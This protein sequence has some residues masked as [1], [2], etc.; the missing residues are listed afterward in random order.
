MRSSDPRSTRPSCR[1]V[2]LSAGVGAGLL[3][4]AA[5]IQAAGGGAVAAG[6][7][8]T[9][10]ARTMS[11]AAWTITTAARTTT[12]A[13]AARTTTTAARTTTTAARATSAAAPAS[14]QEPPGWRWLGPDGEPLPFS[15]DDDVL[16]FLRHAEVLE[17]ELIEGSQNDPLR[18]LLER[19]GVR[20]RAIF[21]TVDR[22]W[23]REWIRGRF[24]VSLRDS[25][26]SEVAAYRLARLLGIDRIPPAVLR[27]I[28]GE[29]GS[30]QLWIEDVETHAEIIRRQETPENPE[31]WARQ[32][33]TVWIFD[34]L[35]YNEDRHPGNLLVDRNGRMW[36]VD[37]TQ[38]FQYDEHLLHREN[39]A[40]IGAGLWERIRASTE[41]EARAAVDN[42]LD[43]EQL[44][45]LLERR[46]LLI[47]HIQGLIDER[48]ADAVL[49]HDGPGI[50]PRDEVEAAGAP[51]PSSSRVRRKLGTNVST[52]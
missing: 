4:A 48:G 51:Q 50:L 12:T 37:H 16:E 29:P 6:T 8:P 10:A 25:Y 27:E 44:E 49:R 31:R 2:G 42:V 15:S 18:V 9:D 45:A 34:N 19:D 33:N 20:A 13:A 39:V 17:S 35:V 24:H 3:L 47:E 26:R 30:L 32:L 11:D 36:M 43:D 38:A 23:H 5:G 46:R 1:A 22:I 14:P 21:R 28:D 7:P 40:T 41:Q 52:K